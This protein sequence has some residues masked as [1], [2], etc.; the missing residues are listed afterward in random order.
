M[1]GVGD[2]SPSSATW[3]ERLAACARLV[4]VPNLFT[5][6]PDVILGLALVAGLGEAVSVEA[7]VGLALA[8]ASLYAA[9]TTL[10]DFFDAAEDARLRPERPIPAGDISRTTALA[11]AV[12]LLVGGVA[13]ATI[14]GGWPAGAVAATLA[15]AIV[16]YD[17]VFKGTF[18]G[19]LFMGASRGLNVLLGAAAVL[20]PTALPARTLA[21]PLVVG[22]YVAAITYMAESES[23]GQES[24]AV[25]VAIGGVAVAAIAC[26][27][28][29]LVRSPTVLETG[30][31]VS[32]LAG[33]VLWTGR[34]L[35]RAYGDPSPET[36]GPAVGA[37]VL[38]LVVLDA[39]FAAPAGI[40]WS[41]AA[42]GFL[43]PA[44]GLSR[45]VDVT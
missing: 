39:A 43:I 20:L 42:V 5:A 44:I 22:S 35:R 23:G 29:V 11:L 40:A 37:C 7:A 14:A 19:F 21:V 6:P 24:L 9:G 34:A 27:L 2:A 4:R 32:A 1:N 38:G 3:S 8:S 13:L 12:A 10:N 28:S 36:I 30:V 17:G 41:A 45:Y 15:V 25:P 16:L 33:F 31:A 18:V 26:L